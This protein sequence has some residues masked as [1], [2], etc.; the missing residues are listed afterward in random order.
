MLAKVLVR[1]AFRSLLMKLL[2]CLSMITYSITHCNLKVLE[3]SPCDNVGTSLQNFVA[4][5]LF[6]TQKNKRQLHGHTR[7]KSVKMHILWGI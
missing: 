6:F 7:A 5:Q 2:K 3:E 1:V 4:I